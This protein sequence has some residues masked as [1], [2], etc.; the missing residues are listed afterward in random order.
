MDPIP[1]EPVDNPFAVARPKATDTMLQRQTSFRGFN[2]LQNASPFKRQVSLRMTELPSTLARQ[3]QGLL[4]LQ[5][6]EKEASATA[7]SGAE[8]SSSNGGQNDKN[9]L[10]LILGL[11]NSGLEDIFRNDGNVNRVESGKNILKKK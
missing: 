7:T 3:Q 10:G 9:E 4:E 8:N 2:P 6:I 5:G 11:D 1:L